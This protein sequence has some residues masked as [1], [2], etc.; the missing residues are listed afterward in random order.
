MR[1]DA[2]RMGITGYM[3][4]GLTWLKALHELEF[5]IARPR[6]AN[7]VERNTPGNIKKMN[8]LLETGFKGDKS[9]DITRREE[10][11]PAIRLLEDLWM[12]N[13]EVFKD[14]EYFNACMTAVTPL[15]VSY[16]G[17][18]GEVYDQPQ[19]AYIIDGDGS[20]NAA[21][22]YQCG[23]CGRKFFMLGEPGYCPRC[24]LRVKDCVDV[25]DLLREKLMSR[26][27]DYSPTLAVLLRDAIDGLDRKEDSAARTSH[28]EGS[29][30]TCDV[31]DDDGLFD[32]MLDFLMGSSKDG[33]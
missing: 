29:V 11:I 15:I 32:D 20:H 24:G 8:D 18:L 14:T 5:E 10:C 26:L 21:F 7:V 22:T 19:N 17:S 12:G 6:A 31:P 4:R 13:V 27:F 25:Q 33:R 30:Y 16:N 3:D 1:F 28:G 2:N 23:G 9:H